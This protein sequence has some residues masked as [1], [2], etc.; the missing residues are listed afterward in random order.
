MQTE[1]GTEF[2]LFNGSPT[3]I[4]IRLP[5]GNK[6]IIRL[7]RMETNL[8]SFRDELGEE[9][10]LPDFV[11]L[12]V[13]ILHGPEK[14]YVSHKLIDLINCR[15]N[16]YVVEDK[17]MHDMTIEELNAK[18]GFILWPDSNVQFIE[19]NLVIKA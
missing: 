13:A 18:K 10:V 2:S 17:Y 3:E 4:S 1:Q 6:K 14:D 15:Q 19:K 8:V 12:E 5:D 7:K 16:T 11:N 9:Y